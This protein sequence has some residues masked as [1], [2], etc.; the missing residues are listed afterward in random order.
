MGI[1]GDLHAKYN[2]LVESDEARRRRKEV[3]DT[4]NKNILEIVFSG[5]AFDLLVGIDK[6]DNKFKT[7]EAKVL[8][9]LGGLRPVAPEKVMSFIN[10]VE[11]PENILKAL[12]PGQVVAVRYWFKPEYR[13]QYGDDFG[14]Q[15]EADPNTKGAEDGI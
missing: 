1:L 9:A 14:K 6:R 12:R 3:V 7:I 5:I 11:I 8:D 10:G 2:K 13:E 15:I 4:F